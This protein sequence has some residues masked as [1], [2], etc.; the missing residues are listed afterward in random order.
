MKYLGQHRLARATAASLFVVFLLAGLA[1]AAPFDEALQIVLRAE[2]DGAGSSEASA[3]RDLLARA[4]AERLPELLRAMNSANVVAANY[5]RSAFDEIVKRSSNSDAGRERL[6]AAKLRIAEFADDAANRGRPRR[7]ALALLDDDF[8]RRLL[9]RGLE[10]PEFRDE[11]VAQTLARGDDLHKAG[12][13][14]AARDAYR[15]AFQHARDSDQVL[16][17][18]A[19]LKSVGV[20]VD[21]TSQLGFI[22][23]WYFLGPFDAPEMTGF[24]KAFP[25]ETAVDLSAKYSGRDGGSLAW[26]AR[27][28]RDALGQFNL[29]QDI[30]AVKEAVGYA[31]CEIELDQRRE[32][33]LRCS[34]D[35]NLTVWID[36]RQLLAREQWLNGTRLD[37][38]VVPVTLD[39]GSHR[40]LVKICQGP[41]H[42]D[43]AVTNNWS[44]QLRLCVADGAGAKFRVVRP[45]AE[46]T[47][48]K[49]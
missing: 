11:A 39:A 44:F 48:A 46:E 21:P 14:A 26:Q 6:D 38:F 8:R 28:T 34:A 12:D 30:G 10:D 43:P 20:D 22:T 15:R 19:R 13:Q 32:L 45:A 49:P 35:D 4:D 24:A 2:K 29:I 41:Q 16:R 33:Q 42:V 47:G 5:L 37:R 7:L 23:R 1:Q 27:A 25:P 31:Y 17:A 36:G 3:A 18:V 9:E 40:V